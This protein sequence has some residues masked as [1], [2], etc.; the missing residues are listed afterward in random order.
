MAKFKIR[1]LRR[2]G[3][4]YF[5]E[6]SKSMR[7]LGYFPE[8]LGA[9]Y[10]HALQRAERLNAEWD[11]D[12]KKPIELPSEEKSKRG[13]IAWL[14]EK[15]KKS[16]HYK[17]REKSTKREFDYYTDLLVKTRQK[18]AASIER[19]HC[20]E[21]YENMISKKGYTKDKANRVMK[22]LR[23]ILSQAIEEGLRKDNPAFNLRL[24]HNEPRSEVWNQYEVAAFVLKATE[25]GRSSIGLAV[26]LAFDLGQRQGDILKLSWGQYDGK[27]YNI[28]QG[29]TGARVAIPLLSDMKASLDATSR[30]SI[31]III[32][33][34]TE[35]PYKA[36][37]FRHHFR[38]IANACGF[39]KKQFLDLRRSSVV[40]LSLAGCS[41]QLISSITG[42]SIHT[43]TQILKVYNP[44][45]REQA[46]AAITLLEAYMGKQ[47]LSGVGI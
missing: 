10:G 22:W 37:D 16:Q 35:R 43:V 8:A 46:A 25:S 20:R 29:K 3:D 9:D 44:P 36:D 33:E 4:L 14:I 32:S 6:P 15:H 39:Q 11:I 19:K 17:D 34:E 28:R 31:Q 45:T 12:K 18:L 26:M 1:H 13:T 24:E 21:L 38:D 5:Y 2:K 47:K 40:R 7:K 42:H 30:K 23:F 41:P 27:F